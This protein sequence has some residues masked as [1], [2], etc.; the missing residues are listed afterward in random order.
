MITKT[1]FNEGK[2]EEL[3]GLDSVEFSKATAGFNNGKPLS[4]SAFKQKAK[5]SLS[6]RGIHFTKTKYKTSKEYDSLLAK[7]IKKH[8]WLQRS[9]IY[10]EIELNKKYNNDYRKIL[11]AF[12]EELTHSFPQ[13]LFVSLPLF[14]LA[15]K[16][17]Y[18]RHKEYVY[19]NHLIFSI[20][21]YILVFIVLLVIIGIREMN[22]ILHWGFLSWLTG[23]LYAFIF[24][25]EYKA[26]RA[27]YQQR[28]AKTILKYILLNN[29]HLLI[30]SLLF[31]IFTF[32]SF[33]KL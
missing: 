33:L 9:L 5:D 21:L 18:F 19:T 17:L 8:N 1:E 7:G 12:L 26:L 16:L 6:A 3:E 28:R 23:L 22:A 2:I 4:R 32:F 10:R 13:M 20:H 31:V 27:F 14:A 15:L 30:I 25:Y 29:L 24:F 11:S